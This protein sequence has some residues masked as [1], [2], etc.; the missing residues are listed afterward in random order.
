MIIEQAIAELYRDTAKFNQLAG[1]ANA[2]EHQDFLNQMKYVQEEIK[3][4]QH[5]LDSHD[6]KESLDGLID[7]MVTI[8]GLVEKFHR[9]GFD[10][11]GAAKKTALNNLSKFPTD[12]K[13]VDESIASYQEKGVKLIAY[14]NDAFDCWVLKDENNKVRKPVGFIE[15]DLSGFLPQQ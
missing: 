14:H 8:F 5:G 6:N 9:L 3:E 1:N 15:N 11:A 4:L 2:L 12:T 7:A 10:V 13:I